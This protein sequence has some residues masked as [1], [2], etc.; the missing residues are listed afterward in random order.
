MSRVWLG[1]LHAE[2][3][4]GYAFNVDVEVFPVPSR[5]TDVRK[6]MRAL[7][8]FDRHVAMGASFCGRR[9]TEMF[10][11]RGLH[12]KLVVGSAGPWKMKFV[13]LFAAA[14]MRKFSRSFD[15]MRRLG[16]Y[17]RIRLR[18]REDVPFFGHVARDAGDT[19]FTDGV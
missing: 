19:Q 4:I 7:S 6:G 10:A 5:V 17:C 12:E 18:C 3:A 2:Q 14:L 1:N 11:R 15:R 8:S 13:A 9:G 16:S